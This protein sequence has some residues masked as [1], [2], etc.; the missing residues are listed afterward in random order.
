[1]KN[2]NFVFFSLTIVA[3]QNLEECDHLQIM[4]IL[5]KKK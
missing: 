1:M 5:H 4:G 3:S 2:K